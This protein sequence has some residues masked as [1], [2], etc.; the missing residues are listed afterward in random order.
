MNYKYHYG[1]KIQTPTMPKKNNMFY[2]ESGFITYVYSYQT[3]IGLFDENTLTFYE[4]A[5]DVK[6]SPTTSKQATTLANWLETQY[7]AKTKRVTYEEGQY[8]IAQL[9]QYE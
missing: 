1:E 7:G 4:W 2:R 9:E 5:H 6:Y 3:M 8:I